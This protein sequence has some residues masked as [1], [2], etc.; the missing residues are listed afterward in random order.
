MAATP[1]TERTPFFEFQTRNNGLHRGLRHLGEAGAMIPGGESVAQLFIVGPSG[2]QA[3]RGTFTEREGLLMGLH[4][5]LARRLKR[6]ERM[7]VKIGV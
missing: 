5:S 1:S 7:E 6:L 4:P 3:Q 2:G